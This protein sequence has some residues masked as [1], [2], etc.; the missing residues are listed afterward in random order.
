[1][2]NE[3]EEFI[4]RMDAKI[5]AETDPTELVLQKIGR[6]LVP[7]IVDTLMSEA[8]SGEFSEDE[9]LELVGKAVGAALFMSIGMF[10]NPHMEH[11]LNMAGRGVLL[12][13]SE[14]RPIICKLPSDRH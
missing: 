2:K 6:A 4:R 1:M 14:L 3:R 12:S 13:L 7:V 8:A 11:A 10:P 5:A 9:M